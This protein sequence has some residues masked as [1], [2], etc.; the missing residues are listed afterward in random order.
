MEPVCRG[1][2]TVNGALVQPGS[3]SRDVVCEILEAGLSDTESFS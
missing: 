2:V 3:G 1:T